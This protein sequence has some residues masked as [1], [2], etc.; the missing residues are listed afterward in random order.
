MKPNRALLALAMVLILSMIGCNLG[1]QRPA[2]SPLDAAA[3]IVEMTLRSQGVS[4]SPGV[5]TTPSASPSLPPA[6]ATTKP[7]LSINTNDAQ[8]RSGPGP[9]FKLI[10][11]YSSGT[12]VDMIAKDTADGY[13]MVKD[14]GSGSS[15]WVKAQ[16]ATPGGSFDLLP[17]VTPASTSAA[18]EV[19]A[20][21]GSSS[22]FHYWDFTCGVGSATVI[23]RWLDTAD[24]ENGYHV[25]RSGQLIADLPANSTTYTDTAAP[26]G[27]TL[28]YSVMAYNDAGE[29][30]P[31]S[32]PT[33]SC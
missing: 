16:D 8:C 3:T 26:T 20:K 9:N 25:Y 28:S 12:I 5:V 17:E 30:V 6:T 11:S 1:V 15:C 10:A 27:T 7:T 18:Q 23:L 2:L 14:P 32:T 22:S 33:F 24:N 31:L 21:P 29:S 19:P 13:W 4:T